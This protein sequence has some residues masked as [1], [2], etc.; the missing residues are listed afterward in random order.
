MDGL[1]KPLY[2][3]RLR[4]NQI[5]LEGLPGCTNSPSVSARP[6]WAGPIFV[7]FIVFHS[8][9][10]SVLHVTTKINVKGNPVR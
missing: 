1:T 9:S 7:F 10:Q 4:R 5:R 6:Q 8:P 3:G 2:L